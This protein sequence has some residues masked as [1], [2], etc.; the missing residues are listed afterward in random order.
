[1]LA[2]MLIL[3]RLAQ[4]AKEQLWVSTWQWTDTGVCHALLHVEAGPTAHLGCGG[5]LVVRKC[6]FSSQER[7]LTS[8]AVLCVPTIRM[9]DAGC[10]SKVT[11]CQDLKG[12]N[13]LPG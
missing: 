1:M 5:Y 12:N 10:L 9:K 2:L 8:F 7:A 6:R 13:H 4:E 3:P 11:D